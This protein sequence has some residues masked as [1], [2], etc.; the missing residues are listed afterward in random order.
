MPWKERS[1]MEKR[2]RF[3]ARVLEVQPDSGPPALTICAK[4]SVRHPGPFYAA[5]LISSARV[6]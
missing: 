5:C 1:V 3:V 2:L 4:D 6:R